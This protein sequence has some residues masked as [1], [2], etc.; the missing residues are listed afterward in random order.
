MDGYKDELLDHNYDGIMEYDNPMPGWWVAIFVITVIWAVIYLVG[1]ELN[2]LPRYGDDLKA[3]QKE[4]AMMREA[5]EASQPKLVIDE[6]MLAEASKDADNRTKGAA[7][8]AA[9]CASCHGDK[10]QGVI[11]PN[12]TDDHWL[13]GRDY[14]AIHKVIVDGTANGMPPWGSILAPQ[15]VVEVVAYIDSVHGTNPAGAKE[16]QGDKYEWDS[17]DGAAK[18]AAPADADKPAEKPADA[19]ADKPADGAGD[20]AKPADGAA[21][22]PQNP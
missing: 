8:Y 15:E 16:P 2:V 12:L 17:A 10:A 14:M 3:G 18:D 20:A 13:Y 4:L 11:G 22:K 6:A 1:I 9:N 19:P 21:E 5:H 7:V